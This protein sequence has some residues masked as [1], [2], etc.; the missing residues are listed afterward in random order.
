MHIGVGY[1][2]PNNKEHAI[3]T[4]IGH[5]NTTSK[6]APRAYGAALI[7]DKSK[8]GEGLPFLRR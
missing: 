4:I 3:I 8:S 5:N 7:V 2:D 6:Y 1:N